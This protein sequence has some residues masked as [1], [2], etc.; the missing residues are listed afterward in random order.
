M[1]RIFILDDHQLFIDGLL[2]S[3]CDDSLIRVVGYALNEAQGLAGIN[4][5]K[6]D[7]VI[8]DINFSMSNEN[9][10]NMLKAI[11][12]TNNSIKILI[13]TSYCDLALIE[14]ARQSGAEGF[15]VKNISIR[16]LR[17]TLLEIYD[18]QIVF[19][20]KQRT[21]NPEYTY[22]RPVL[23]ER[24]IEIIQLLAEGYI[25]KEIALK[26]NIAETTVNDHIDRAK[27]KL[28]ARNTSELVYLAVKNRYI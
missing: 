5:L 19:K 24:A 11:K 18:D 17:E 14:Q 2:N 22:V 25:V 7:I 28:C 1:V 9:G 10:I 8:L 15:K 23:S 26:I 3:F 27:K 12:K 21:D 6:P 4:E 16:E 13:L 20:Y